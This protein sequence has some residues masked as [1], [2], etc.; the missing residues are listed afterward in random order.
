M[1]VSDQQWDLGT[2]AL[3]GKDG[4]TA[5]AAGT[6]FNAHLH[7]TVNAQAAIDGAAAPTGSNVFA[8]MADVGGGGLTLTATTLTES[9]TG[10]IADDG[11]NHDFTIAVP[12]GVGHIHTVVLTKTAG[13]ATGSRFANVELYLDSGRTAALETNLFYSGF[14]YPDT[15]RSFKLFMAESAANTS[16]FTLYGRFNDQTA[17]A[18][19]IQVDIDFKILYYI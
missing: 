17:S 3:N 14:T 15:Q 5:R 1:A 13:T 18:Q 2:E 4:D 16:A 10:A 11:T 7:Q 6:K 19:T 8:T 12:A 9:M